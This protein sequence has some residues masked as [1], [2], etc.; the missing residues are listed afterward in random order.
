MFQPRFWFLT[1]MVVYTVAAR[2]TPYVL[3][4]R[5]LSIDPET[6]I[7]PWNFSPLTA[8]CLFGAAHF[9]DRRWSYAV[10]LGAL[11]LSD[12]AI[13]LLMGDVRFGFYPGQPFVYGGF[14]ITITLGMWL[15]R[16]HSVASIAGTGL[17]AETIF[18]LVTNFGMWAFGNTYSHD[19]IGL[20]ACHVAAIPFFGRSLL[21]TA[22]FS[23]VLFS[24][25][26]VRRTSYAPALVPAP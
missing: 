14:A 26:A 4:L 2:I 17:L 15:R 3:H 7:Y 10:P 5:G 16:H 22:L 12:L 6:T 13:G 8:L 21:S 11:L 19:W 20:T 9:A 18:F 25:V 1:T 23:S 24:R